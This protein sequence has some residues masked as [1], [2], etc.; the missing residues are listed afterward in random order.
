MLKNMTILE[1][2]KKDQVLSRKGVLSKKHSPWLTTLIG[3]I[4]IVGK[5]NGNRTTTDDETI[6]VIEKF[7]KGVIESIAHIK[8]NNLITY[9]E[10]LAELQEELELY[11]KYLPIQ[12]SD[13]DLKDKIESIIKTIPNASLKSMGIVM[14]QLKEKYNGQYDGKKASIIIKEFLNV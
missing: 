14:A 13:E 4:E 5:N 12:L 10:K 1:E 3:E 2:I 6:K 7:K 8:N 11:E 9:P